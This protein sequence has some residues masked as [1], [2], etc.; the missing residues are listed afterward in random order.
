VVFAL[1]VVPLLVA[2]GFAVDRI[3]LDD[4]RTEMQAAIDGAA[5]A[6]AM[7]EEMA[8]ADRVRLARK[9]FK[10]N[11]A[12][13]GRDGLEIDVDISPTTVTVTSTFPFRTSLMALAGINSADVQ[14]SAEVM[15]PSTSN[16]EVVLVLDYSYSMMSSNKYQRM[17]E[18][19]TA[20]VNDLDAGIDDG[21]LKI[22]LV[23]FSAMVRT[24]MPASYVTQPAASE[25]WTGCTQDRKY[26]YNITVDTPTGDVRTQ[27]G[28]FD[29]TSENSGSYD[30]SHYASKHLDILPLTTDMTAV[31]A[32][33]A[34]MLPLGNTNIALGAEFGWNL[35]DPQAP[36]EEAV[37]YT[38]KKTRKY[39]VL[40]TDGV[41]TSKN[42]GAGD[43]RSKSNGNANLL[44]LCSAMA[45][46]GITVFTIAYDITDPAV[47]TLLQNCAGERYYEPDVSGS[48]IKKVFASIT[49]EIRNDHIRIAR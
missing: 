27:W 16:A 13:G 20:M 18:A 35:L 6:A 44:E 24:S 38:N 2:T 41:Q 49:K 36:F 10:Q 40:L 5:L 19:A 43:T 1:T 23:P 29:A 37:A 30:C 4:V 11:F 28:Y 14:V 26:P 22:G 47:T 25:T 15:L 48:E 8:D 45:D 9:Y 46:A 17:A 33:L 31:T 39:L 3:R 34:E 42:W 21:K 12:Y 7:A 32:K